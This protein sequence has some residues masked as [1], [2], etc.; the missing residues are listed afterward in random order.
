M[1]KHLFFIVLFLKITLLFSQGGTRGAWLRSGDP[2]YV[3]N[4]N[5]HYAYSNNEASLFLS[6]IISIPMDN[7]YI[8][9]IDFYGEG[10]IVDVDNDLV[11]GFKDAYNINLQ[12]QLVSNG[13]DQGRRIPNRIPVVDYNNDLQLSRFVVSDRVSNI[14]L[15]NAPIQQNT[16]QEMARM[17]RKDGAGKIII[18]GFS[19]FEPEITLLEKELEKIGFYHAPNYILEAPFNEIKGFTN[20]PRVYKS[21]KIKIV[22][23]KKISSLNPKLN[24]EISQDEMTKVDYR[25]LLGLNADLSGGIKGTI[26]KPG[27]KI[28][29]TVYAYDGTQVNGIQKFRESDVSRNKLVYKA[30]SDV[31]DTVN[32]IEKTYVVPYGFARKLDGSYRTLGSTSSN[33]MKLLGSDSS[34][35]WTDS[36]CSLS[37]VRFTRWLTWGIKSLF[38]NNIHYQCQDVV[39]KINTGT[40]PVLVE[41]RLKDATL[42]DLKIPGIRD[43]NIIVDFI[44]TTKEPQQYKIIKNL[45]ITILESPNDSHT[46]GFYKQ[47]IENDLKEVNTYYTDKTGKTKCPEVTAMIGNPR[48]L[49]KDVDLIIRKGSR[50]SYNFQSDTEV[51]DLEE[52]TELNDNDDE[53]VQL[54][55]AHTVLSTTS[56]DPQKNTIRG[57]TYNEGELIKDDHFCIFSYDAM[58]NV[59]PNLVGTSG[60]TMAHELG[61][62]FGL[63]HPFSGGCSQADGGDGIADTPPTVGEHWYIADLGTPLEHY[64]ENPCENVPHLCNGIRRQVENIMDYGPCRWLF[65]KEQSLRMTKR[66]ETK[67][68]LFDTELFYDSSVNPH[69]IAITVEDERDAKRRRKRELLNNDFSMRMLYPNSQKAYYNLEIVSDQP[70]KATVRIFDIYSTLLYKAYYSVENGLNHFPIKP[71]FF[72]KGGLYLVTYISD[73]GRS[74]KIKFLGSQ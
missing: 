38:Y 37:V 2:N 65:T 3:T 63:L 36:G 66:I 55:F 25:S 23:E 64:L 42:Y 19:H 22:G 1:K 67:P 45:R 21:K 68:S 73:N 48:I 33:N 6:S 32:F 56:R 54:L 39:T 49:F 9:L 60:S 15:M 70:E 5:L 50:E 31:T 59:D 11:T 29:V 7:S 26:D 34:S 51:E 71:R 46:L 40:Q 4:K 28:E 58:F 10:R 12:Y 61:H 62:Y 53:T 30:Y 35:G 44:D 13:P 20:K 16:A 17:I 43:T 74:E 72:K 24:Q 27:G 52:E 41:I 18:Y 8:H 57:Y 14:T 69:K 47:K